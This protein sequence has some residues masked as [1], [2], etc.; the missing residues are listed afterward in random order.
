MELKNELSAEIVF[1]SWVKW[2]FIILALSKLWLI[3]A[4]SIYAIGWAMHDDFLFLKLAKVLLSGKWLGHYNNLTLIKGMFYPL[5]I[6]ATF[7]LGV[8]LMPAQHILYIAACAALIIAVR[9]LMPKP[10]I[11]L[12]FYAILLFNPI[13]YTDHVMTRVM[14]EG[15]YP[16]LTILVIANAIGILSRYNRPLKNIKMWSIG[17]GFSLSAFWLTREE[18]IWIIPSL[19]MIIIFSV[20]KI[21][22]TKP[23]DW[24]KL[25]LVCILP[26]LIWVVSLGIVAGINKVYYGAFI[27]VETKSRSFLSAYGALLRVKHVNWH[28]YMPV[29]KET[30]ERIYKVSPAFAELRPYLEG[31]IGRVWIPIGCKVLSVCDDISGGWFMWAFREAVA[32]AGYHTTAVS[33]RDYYYRIAN[34]INAACTQ[35]NLDCG[36]KQASLMPPWRSE[37]LQPLIKTLTRAAVFMVRFEGFNAH[38]SPSEGNEES[39]TQFRDLTRG[40]L[41]PSNQF[42]IMG[43][44]AGLKYQSKIDNVKIKVLTQIGTAYQNAMPVLVILSLLIYIFSIIQGLRKRS[45]T[46]LMILN[47]SLLLAI[48]ARI[49]ILSLIDITSFPA[50]NTIYLSP[51]YPLLLIFMYMCISFY[52]RSEYSLFRVYR[53]VYRKNLP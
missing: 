9:P 35:G 50:I 47:T 19:F 14:R 8:P 25:S 31:N 6:A 15:I 24:R 13:S 16:A 7:I 53:R 21:W 23:I 22:K 4:Q 48:I 49:F 38:S 43:G 12:L 2:S 27:T 26:F 5:W 34:E 28:P 32:A 45:N 52:W 10:V 30:R 39:L 11:L 3:S 1:P 18:S 29:P 33:A 37:Y 41:S 42:Q 51:A 46:S 40:R 17:L 44:V 20:F 36:A